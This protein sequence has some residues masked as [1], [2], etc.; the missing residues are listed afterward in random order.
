MIFN[1]LRWLRHISFVCFHFLKDGGVFI[2]SLIPIKIL[3]CKQESNLK[4]TILLMTQ[5]KA[6]IL[7]LGRMTSLIQTKL[8]R[9]QSYRLRKR[10]TSVECFK[11]TAKKFSWLR[12]LLKTDNNF[13]VT[14]F[15]RE[16]TTSKEGHGLNPKKI[17]QIIPNFQTLSFESRNNYNSS[18]Q[19][20]RADSSNKILRGWVEW[21]LM[22]IEWS[23]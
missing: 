11:D 15:W 6:R 17:Q 5:L 14:K 13:W 23:S 10:V 7:K 19:T 9:N 21:S 8:N 2:T 1:S 18:W 12:L 20:L 16:S 4:P 22:K 3:K